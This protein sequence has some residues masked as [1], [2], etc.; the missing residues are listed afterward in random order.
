MKTKKLLLSLCIIS[1]SLATLNA[2]SSSPT[3]GNVYSAAQ[4]GV[5]QEVQF[6]TVIGIRNVIIEEDSGGTGEAAGA[7][8]GATAGSEIGKGKGRIV[9]GVIGAVAGSAIGGVIDRD[10]QAEPGIELTLRMND[11]RNVAIVQLAGEM[12]RVGET[13][14]VLTG[15]DG[16]TRVTH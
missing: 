12:F 14:K 5:M 1:I 7:I 15:S 16:Q 4:T 9:G 2:C 13:V 10:T 3:S 6:A 8:I 11:G